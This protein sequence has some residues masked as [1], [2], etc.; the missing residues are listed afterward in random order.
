MAGAEGGLCLSCLIRELL[1]LFVPLCPAHVCTQRE[2]RRREPAGWRRR[3]G[4]PMWV[5]NTVLIGGGVV[6]LAPVNTFNHFSC[7]SG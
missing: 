7:L 5:H 6:L 1:G 3:S 2:Q 4:T